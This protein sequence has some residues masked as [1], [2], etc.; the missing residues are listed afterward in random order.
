MKARTIANPAAV[1]REQSVTLC[2]WLLLGHR[3][4]VAVS[5]FLAICAVKNIATRSM[6][7]VQQ[8]EKR[9]GLNA[10]AFSKSGIAST[11][12][13]IVT[14]VGSFA[15]WKSQ[16]NSRDS[17]YGSLLK[18][19]MRG[20]GDCVLELIHCRLSIRRGCRAIRSIRASIFLVGL[21]S[22]LGGCVRDLCSLACPSRKRCSGTVT[23]AR[24]SF[25]S[26]LRLQRAFPGGGHE[27]GC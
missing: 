10:A 8:R 6:A 24:V 14:I 1:E 26:Q 13:S 23:G 5:V 18:Y 12:L 7:E 22:R 25:G 3:A 2:Y 4:E 15:N 27:V 9:V 11:L 21:K 19:L 20:E 16:A 17:L